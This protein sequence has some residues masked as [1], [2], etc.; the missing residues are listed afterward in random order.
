MDNIPFEVFPENLQN[1]ITK[2]FSFQKA[3]TFVDGRK[4]LSSLHPFDTKLDETRFEDLQKLERKVEKRLKRN[5]QKGRLAKSP[6]KP[7]I[8]QI[9]VDDWG[10][11]NWGNFKRD[12][13]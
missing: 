7:H 12:N 3:I 4:T 6:S 9:L 1:E 10:W 2:K 5:K 8:I 11:N 13:I